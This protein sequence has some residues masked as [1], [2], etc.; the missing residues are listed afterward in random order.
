MIATNYNPVKSKVLV[1]DEGLEKLDSAFGRNTKVLVDE[2]TKRDV[3]VSTAV[4]EEEALAAI[5]SDASIHGVLLS[6]ELTGAGKDGKRPA[7]ILLNEL[8]QRHRNIPVFLM[9]KNSEQVKTINEDVMTKVEEFVWMLEDTADFIAGRMIAAVDRYRA[10]LLPPFAAALA[11]YSKLREQSWS[12][13]GHQ[14][15]IAFT[16]LPVGRAFFD[17]YGENLF[18]TDMGIERGQLGSLLDHTGPVAESEKYAAKV[19]GA[20]RSYNVTGGTSGSNRTIMQASMVEDDVVICDRNCH[21]SIEQGLMLTGARPVYLVPTRNQYGIIGP[22]PAS[23]MSVE[24][25]TN[26][27]ETS[28]LTK[29]L[30]NKDP[31]YS[32]LTSCTYDGLCYNAVDVENLLGQ[33]SPRVHMDEAWYGYARFNPIYKDHFAMRD[34]AGK[35]DPNAPTVFAT[36]ST[37]KLLAALSQ[38]SYIHVRDGRDAI[39]HDRF[40][41]SYM[42][43]ATT[44]PLYSIVASNDIASAMM[45]GEGGTM[46]TTDAIKEAVSFR[47]AVGKTFKRHESKGDWFFKPWNAET[48]VDPATGKSYPFEEAPSELLVAEQ[49]CWR[50]DPKDK[51]HGFNDLQDNWVMLDPIKVSLLTPGMSEDGELLDTGVPAELFTAYASRFGIVPTR[52]TDFQVMFLFSIG[53][54]KGKWATL[55]NTLLSFKRHYDENAPLSQVLPELVSGNPERYG[56]LGLK[57]LGDQMFEFLKMNDPGKALN[58]AYSMIPQPV[59]TPRAAFQQLV[60]DNVELVPADK[61]AGRVAANAVMPYPPG[62][63]MM[64][65]GEKFDE[66]NSP[67][68]EYMLKLGLWDAMFPGFE[69]EVEGAEVIDGVYNVL[70]LK[71]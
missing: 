12:A 58:D 26:K 65:S 31:V 27:I 55:I 11:K 64:M 70:C 22:V 41:Q 10:Q 61:L 59:M 40:N 38:A 37:H 50:L 46:L 42:M 13:P 56:N 6:W 47:Q 35:N 29:D 51:W 1:I 5:V 45:D 21:K 67:Q 43:H 44:S 28:P 54:T 71:A 32:V 8:A 39:P 53:V 3:Y 18:R 36:H 16:K 24:S 25:I 66:S 57:D 68:I 48:V 33:S 4:S 20:D 52:T 9:A 19:F 49:S 17:F 62:I 30:E 34:G 60:K 14:G 15:G 69:H 23:D 63:P 2:L 7:E